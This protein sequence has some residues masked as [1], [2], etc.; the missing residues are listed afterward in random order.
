MTQ[1]A[2]LVLG[3]IGVGVMG[4]PMC[5]HLATKSGARVLACD[6]NPEPLERLAQHGVTRAS[7]EQIAN[8]ASIIFLSL[9]SGEAV[10]SVV[11]GADGSNGEDGLAARLH[12]GQCVVD[13][14]TSSVDITL[15]VAE[16]LARR[17][18]R[19]ADAPVMR[20]RAAAEAG[21]LAVPVGADAD[22]YARLEPLIRTFASDVLHAGKVSAGQ[23]VKILNNMVLYE[24]VLALA[25]AAAIGRRAG[26]DPQVLFDALSKGSAD[27]FALRNHGFKAILPQAFPEKAFPVSYARK[28]VSY[29]VALAER[30]GVDACGARNLVETFD[31][32]IAA[33]HGERYAPAIS[34][35]FEGK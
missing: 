22:L 5:R 33:G 18:V 34:L 25:E 16:A 31:R 32:A 4:E 8:E 35:L 28:D 17:H 29:A 23:V 30:V 26:V 12:E 13:L 1:P 14:S 21:T 20:T 6:R 15:D 27:S 11:C 3:F 2:S 24:T 10:R 19:F 7:V 9:P